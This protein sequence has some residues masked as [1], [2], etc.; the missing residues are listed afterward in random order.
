MRDLIAIAYPD[1]AAAKRARENLAEGVKKGLLEVEDVV[2]I[3]YGDDGSVYPV[4]GGWEVGFDAVYG[5]AAGGLIG[6][7]LLGPLLGMAA[8]AAG[9]AAAGRVAWKKR[10]DDDV[11]SDRFVSDLWETLTPGTAAMI[12][13][14]SEGILEKVLPHLQL[15]EPGRVIH[16]SL[17]D[18]YEA[19]LEKALEAAKPSP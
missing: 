5:A 15:H 4:L 9:A 6:L 3:A 7:I 19:Q 8:G 11:I 18:E 12:V 13:L 2:V 16:T 10:F 17:S 1:K 14:V